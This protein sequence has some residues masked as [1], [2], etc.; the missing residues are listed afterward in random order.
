V[1]VVLD[2]YTRQETGDRPRVG[3]RLSGSNQSP[4]AASY[5]GVVNSLAVGYGLNEIAWIHLIM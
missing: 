1:N 3:E 4:N 5:G 2:Y